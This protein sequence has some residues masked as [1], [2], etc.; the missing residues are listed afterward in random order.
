MTR[1]LLKALLAAGLLA[2]VAMPAG[3]HRN[4]LQPSATTFSGTD[5]W[6]SFDAAESSD[7]FFPDHRALGFAMMKVWAPDGSAGQI[8]NGNDGHFR[9]TFDVQLNKAGTWAIGME[10]NRLFGSFKINGE[11]WRLGRF[12]RPMTP[13][14]GGAPQVKSVATVAE[15]PADA[16]DVK[17]SEMSG[18]NLVFVTAGAPTTTVFQPTGK[19]LEMVPVTHPDELVSNEVAS[20]RFLI[21][22][23]P[24]AG[25]KVV[26]LP[27]GKRYIEGQDE[28][29]LTT[30]SDGLLKVK[31]PHAGLY[32]I[33]TTATDQHP[34][35]P[36][37]TERRMSYTMTVDVL[38]P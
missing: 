36:R 5:A 21:D 6:V 23:Q 9:T 20:F 3:A 13:P 16:T 33:G 7:V 35:E 17:I 28:I 26:I 30:G 15:I 10:M 27:A 31:W 11:E 19:G 25:L 18:R 38:A 14:A 2:A 1:P 24:A 4:W 34:S 22:G 32:W 29:D 12:G 8:Q 37:A